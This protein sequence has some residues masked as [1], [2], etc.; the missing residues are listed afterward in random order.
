MRLN[1]KDTLFE[2]PILRIRNVIRD[3]MME[4]LKSREKDYIEERVATILKQPKLVAK[5]VLKQMEQEDYIVLKKVKYGNNFQYELTETE[6]GSRF[7]VAT[8][9]PPISRE[10]A[11]QLLN[12]LIERAKQVNANKE[13]V[14]FVE[15][16]KVFGSY[17]TDKEILGDLDVAIKLTRKYEG[18][19]F[20][21][22]NHKRADFAKAS[23]RVFSSYLEEICWPQREIMLLLKT[24]KKG[25]SLHDEDEDEIVK[26]TTTKIVYEFHP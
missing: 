8:G 19:Q 21:N 4:R 22:E 24:K 9:N 20:K 2:Q 13:L 18:D 7:G 14:Y 10:K 3:A 12:E 16:I 6:K 17:L 23:G 5:K 11:A 1:P 26:R 15:I 25:L